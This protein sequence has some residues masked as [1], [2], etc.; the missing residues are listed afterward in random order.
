MTLFQRL[1]RYGGLY[2]LMQDGTVFPIRCSISMS[3]VGRVSHSLSWRTGMSFSGWMLTFGP[4]GEETGVAWTTML[5]Q[6]ESVW[7]RF[8]CSEKANQ[9][10]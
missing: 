10:Q 3:G 4:Y 7:L 8:G 5:Q 2:S 6:P 1:P 9:S